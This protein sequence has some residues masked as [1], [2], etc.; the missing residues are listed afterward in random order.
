MLLALAFVA[1][2]SGGGE[3]VS[4]P[5][6]SGEPAQAQSADA[7]LMDF[8]APRLGGGQVTGSE[9]QGKDVALWFWAPW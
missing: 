8:E 9:L 2:C 4:F 3:S 6:P 1:S 5:K 7:D